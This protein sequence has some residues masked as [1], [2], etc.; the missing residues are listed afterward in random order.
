MKKYFI[1]IHNEP[2]QDIIASAVHYN[3]RDVFLD[4]YRR[5]FVFFGNNEHDISFRTLLWA[6]DDNDDDISNF[7]IS[8]NEWFEQDFISNILKSCLDEK[9]IKTNFC[10]AEYSTN[11][12]CKI[13]KN[14]LNETF[15][16]FNYIENKSTSR[17]FCK[18]VK[19]RLFA[20]KLKFFVAKEGFVK[21]IVICTHKKDSEID[22]SIDEF[23]DYGVDI[24]IELLAIEAEYSQCSLDALEAKLI[25][26]KY[27]KA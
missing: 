22:A 25:D 12:L 11:Q 26:K 8:P 9:H 5:S 24:D 19:G 7:S 17:I 20:N 16:R 13:L 4:F 2:L 27:Y 18:G 15:R 6:V 21:C 23:I 1:N 10:Y 14:Y 3:I